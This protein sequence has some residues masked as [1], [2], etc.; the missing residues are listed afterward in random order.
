MFEKTKDKSNAC[1][2]KKVTKRQERFSISHRNALAE[3]QL[4]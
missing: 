4:L 2:S 3:N 1:E